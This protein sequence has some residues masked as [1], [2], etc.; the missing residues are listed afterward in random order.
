M[1]VVLTGEQW[2]KALE[3][4]HT[5]SICARHGI[6]Q[7]KVLHRLHFSNV[8]LSKMFP[9]IDSTCDRCGLSPASLAHPFWHCANL[10]T[11]WSSIFKMV[12]QPDHVI[13]IFG[14]VGEDNNNLSGSKLKIIQFV[15]L[16]AGRLILLLEESSAT[17]SSSVAEVGDA[18]SQT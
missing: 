15:T 1:G 14:V 3:G 6:V 12:I 17:E 16:L 4:V 10:Y 11:Y 8:K 5:T 13:A 18:A 9:D 2:R 7:L